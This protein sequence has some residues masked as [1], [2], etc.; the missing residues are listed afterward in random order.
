M[1]KSILFWLLATVFLITAPRAEAQQAG[2]IFRIGYLDSSTASGSA[3]FVKVFLQELIKL[4][5]I[6]GKNFTVEYRF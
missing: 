5:W 1:M 2:K 6:E 3:V 4:G